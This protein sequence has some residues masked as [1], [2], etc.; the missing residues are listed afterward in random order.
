VSLKLQLVGDTTVQV[1]AKPE[2]IRD[3]NSMIEEV[4]PHSGLGTSTFQKML[5][6]VA[7][8]VKAAPL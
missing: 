5:D 1:E 6:E 8:R 2:M 7:K 3:P 4:V